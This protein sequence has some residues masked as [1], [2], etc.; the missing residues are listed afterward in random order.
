MSDPGELRIGIA[1]REAAIVAIGEHLATGRLEP[2]EYERRVGAASLARTY[3]DLRPLFA[4]LPPPHPPGPL[5]NSGPG[6]LPGDLREQLTAEGLL[7][8]AEDLAG[9]M[10]YRRYRA[11]GQRIR[12]REIGVRGAVAVSRV[13]LL[14]WAS[15]A[16]RV[17]LPFD[18]HLWHAVEV[19]V[20]GG[21]WLRVTTDVG[22]FHHDRSGRIVLRLHTFEATTVARMLATTL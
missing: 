10:T 21:D 20:D 1:E 13:R 15:G 19:A 9:S 2:D 12:H 4:D 5:A 17:D 6:Y 8:L 7:V 16:K 3:A 22:A 18:H 11:P 14:I